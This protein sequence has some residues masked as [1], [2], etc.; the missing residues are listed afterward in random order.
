[1]KTTLKALT[2]ALLI[3]TSASAS[4]WHPFSDA[5]FSNNNG[6]THTFSD[7]ASDFMGDIDV[8]MD[9]NVSFS[10]KAHGKGQTSA[11]SRYYGYGYNQ[12]NPYYGYSPYGYAPIAPTAPNLA[13]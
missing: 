6:F 9:I 7:I 2:A 1:M 4:A 8:D 11:N 10:T 12:Y 13:K 5:P 3:S